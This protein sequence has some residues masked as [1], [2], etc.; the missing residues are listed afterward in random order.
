MQIILAG[1]PQ[2]AEK[3][4][5]PD[6]VQLRQRISILARLTAF[7]PEET[8][9][10]IVHRLQL[11]GYTGP[12]LFTSAALDLI[13]EYSNGIPR[14]INNICFNALSWGCAMKKRL[15]DGEILREVGAELAVNM[16][17]QDEP[18]SS[19]PVTHIDRVI[20]A[21]RFVL[22]SRPASRKW[23]AE[24]TATVALL[25]LGLFGAYRLQRSHS[26]AVVG[27]RL[28]APTASALPPGNPVPVAG[29]PALLA[30]EP[31]EASREASKVI[32][33]A[34]TESEANDQAIVVVEPDQSLSRIIYRYF[35][36]SEPGMLEEV[37]Q[38]NPSIL[39]PDHIEVGQRIRLPRMQGG[40]Q[41]F[42]ASHQNPNGENSRG[43]SNL[44]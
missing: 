32:G 6:L 42:S 41:E 33:P 17:R 44:E 40:S 4:A 3:L 20:P 11:A 14:N 22:S 28:S 24:T 36:R 34:A 19:G 8:T 21:P 5:R 10:Y 29:A 35:G 1:Q 15:I 16:V 2:L 26:A 25:L 43:G 18:S 12:R 7:S 27:E 37:M 9:Q 30:P 38:L 23:I 39:N 13:A 31:L